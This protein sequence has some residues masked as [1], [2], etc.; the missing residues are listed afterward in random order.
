MAQWHLCCDSEEIG[1]KTTCVDCS[2]IMSEP[3]DSMP[4][5]SEDSQ[6]V[7]QKSSGSWSEWASEHQQALWGV[8]AGSIALIL[9]VTVRSLTRNRV[10]A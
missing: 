9:G 6:E 1:L 4:G 3:I 2:V 5:N 8:A 10:S 7:V